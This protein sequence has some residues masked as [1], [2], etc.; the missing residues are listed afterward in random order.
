MTVPLVLLSGG[1]IAGGLLNLPL[2]DDLKFLE[3]WLEPVV[4]GAE[5]H[6]TLGTGAKWVLALDLGGR[7]ADRHRRRRRGLPAT[8]GRPRP[9]RAARVL[10]RGWY[11]DETMARVAGGPGRRLFDAVAWFDRNVIDGAV[12]GVATLVRS[13]GSRV[14]TLQTGFVR[15]YAVGVGA[16]AVA[17]LVYVILRVYL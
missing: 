6:L 17:L 11:I 1:A 12:N 16:G 4:E 14:R 2:T 15:T 10:A 7:R 5:H 3:H 13:T 8:P 9:Y